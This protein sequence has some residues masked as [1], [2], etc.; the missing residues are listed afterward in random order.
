MTNK[1]EITLLKLD[2]VCKAIKIS[3]PTLLNY[4]KTGKLRGIRIGGQW[5]VSLSEL[6]RFGKEGNS[7]NP[8]LNLEDI[9]I[10]D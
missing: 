3:Y 2:Q 5:R 9:N 10:E 6:K 4:I 8:T 7:D 1:D